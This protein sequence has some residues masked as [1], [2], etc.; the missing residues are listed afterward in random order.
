MKKRFVAIISSILALL[1]CLSVSGC[2]LIRTNNKADLAQTVATVQI[3]EDAPKDEIKKQ[4]MVMSYINYGYYAY[5]GYSAEVVFK[6]IIKNL[7]NS[8]ILV[9]NAM[10]EFDGG[11]APF[12]TVYKNASITD[13]WNPERYLT[14]ENEMDG[15]TLV[16][17][18]AVKEIEYQSIKHMNDFIKGYVETEEQGVSDTL[19][20]SARVAPTNAQNDETVSEQE[21]LDYIAKGIDTGAND[22]KVRTA[23]ANVLKV[24]KNNELLGDDYDGDIK[25]SDYYKNVVKSYQESKIIDIYENCIKNAERSKITLNDLKANY[26]EMYEEQ[27]NFTNSEFATAISNATYDNPIVYL[28]SGGYGFVYNLLLGASKTQSSL[29]SAIEGSKAEKSLERR[30]ILEGLTIK[31]LRSSWILAGYDFDATTKKF[32]GDYTLTDSANSLAFNGEVELVKAK[33]EEKG[34]PAE[35]RVKATEMGLKQFVGYMNNY[36]FGDETVGV[37]GT[38]DIYRTYGTDTEPVEFEEKIGELLFAYSTDP[39]SLNTYKGYVIS[40][41]ILGQETYAQEFADAGRELIASTTKYNYSMVATD[42]GYHIMFFVKE[43]DVNTGYATLEDYLTYLKADKGGFASWEEYYADMLANWTDENADTD[44][45]LYKLQNLYA[46]KTVT[47]KLSNV[48][49]SII[50]TYRKDT[51]KVKIYQ[52]RF[53]DLLEQ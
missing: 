40:P 50:E 35:Y 3:S 10:K 45:Y 43:L 32:T 27:Q 8:R 52:D 34:T 15:T 5:S 2:K 12:N 16:K 17:L 42:Y 21:K 19:T 20:E 39:G 36:L 1:M 37:E 18:S 49:S 9:Q 30:A 26:L 7:V 38:G 25:K 29:I 24:L 51:S 4:E 53:S 14:T 47:T 6:T 13:K 48:E 41:S 46:D 28:P 22:T 23:Y 11:V 31:D 33:D 44:F